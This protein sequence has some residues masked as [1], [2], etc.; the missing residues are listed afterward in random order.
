[1]DAG[2]VALVASNLHATIIAKLCK[3]RCPPIA[4]YTSLLTANSEIKI[5]SSRSV[6]PN[7]TGLHCGFENLFSFIGDYPFF[8]L[9]WISSN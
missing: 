5:Q 2:D 3:I 8:V 9:Q 4:D 6:F 1:M 7:E